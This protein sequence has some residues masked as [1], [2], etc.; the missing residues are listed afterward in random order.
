LQCI[1]KAQS[2]DPDKIVAT[3][4]KM[5]SVDTIWGKG[6]WGGQEIFGVNH[7]IIRPVT[8]SRIA[9]GK[10]EQLNFVEK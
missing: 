5:M 6:R 7:V 3:I 1:E 9:N 2:L 4:E 10:V 8:I